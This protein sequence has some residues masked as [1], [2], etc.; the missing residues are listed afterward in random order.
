MSLSLPVRQKGLKMNKNIEGSKNLKTS[1]EKGVVSSSLLCV[2]GCLDFHGGEKR[3]HKDCPFYPE[4]F[5]K[6]YDDLLAKAM[7]NI[8]RWCNTCMSNNNIMNYNCRV[9]LKAEEP[10]MYVKLDT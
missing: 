6:M 5:S 4:S 1:R 8:K 2:A 3:H 7:N 9:C 10:M